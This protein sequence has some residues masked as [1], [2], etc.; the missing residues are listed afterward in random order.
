MY[1][2][3]SFILFILTIISYFV[4]YGLADAL[5]L[6]N[7]FFYISFGIFV[8]VQKYLSLYHN[9]RA[10]NTLQISYSKKTEE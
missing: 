1:L 8:M 6:Q 5:T 2:V 3:E 4:I 9:I 10:F 7:L